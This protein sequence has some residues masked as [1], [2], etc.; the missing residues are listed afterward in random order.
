MVGYLPTE[1][2]KITFLSQSQTTPQELFDFGS[3]FCVRSSS[4]CSRRETSSSSF[5]IYLLNLYA[6]EELISGDTI[7][8]VSGCAEDTLHFASRCPCFALWGS[9]V[10]LWSAALPTSMSHF[11]TAGQTSLE[12]D[13]ESDL[14]SW[15]L[16][17]RALHAGPSSDL[18]SQ[19]LNWRY[20][21]PSY[22]ASPEDC[23]VKS[24]W[25]WLKL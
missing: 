23:W 22:Q 9:L 5:F 13:C 3:S 19:P 25:G 10:R 15:L 6:N 16:A 20:L 24:E 4:S 18:E 21:S 17:V 14:Y 1:M 11:Q 8:G 2:N 7:K 12:T